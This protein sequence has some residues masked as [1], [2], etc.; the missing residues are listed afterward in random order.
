M[1]FSASSSV[2]F[3]VGPL[4]TGVVVNAATL[5]GFVSNNP[6]DPC[7]ESCGNRSIQV[8]GY[9]GTGA[10]QLA[11]FDTADLLGSSVIGTGVFQ[12]EL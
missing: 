7:P 3:A 6:F 1:R 2:E 10:V 9:D 8:H 4:P 5:T 11:N 12:P